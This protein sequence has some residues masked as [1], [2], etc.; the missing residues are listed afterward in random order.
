MLKKKVSVLIKKILVKKDAL[1]AGCCF[2]LVYFAM[3]LMG[4]IFFFSPGPK[5]GIKETFRMPRQLI[6][7]AKE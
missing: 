4:G 5:P 2:N 1:D 7:P 3:E 6:K